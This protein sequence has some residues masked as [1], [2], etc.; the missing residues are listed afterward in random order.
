MDA[1][2]FLWESGYFAQHCVT[3][4]FGKEG[5]LTLAWER[6]RE[7][8]AAHAAGIQKINMHRDLQ[9]ENVM[10]RRGRVRFIDFQG[11]RLGP[12]HY[13]AASLLF[14]PYID[15][16]NE[17]SIDGLIDYYLTKKGMASDTDKNDF[18]VC[19]AQRLMQALG[20]YGNLSL[21]KSKPHYRRFIPVAI[22]RLS[23]IFNN[24]LLDYPAMGEVVNGCLR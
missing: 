23:N 21:H 16:L 15:Q 4:F 9:S 13:D 12:A 18:Y 3:G 24:H 6:E 22:G 1:E 14:D 7:R 2:T 10:I 11:A 19:A 8:M 5:L 17:S 20:A